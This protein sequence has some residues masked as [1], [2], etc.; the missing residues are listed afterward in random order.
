VLIETIRAIGIVLQP[1]MPETMGKL[2]DQLGVAY[3][4]RDFAAIAVKLVPGT[5][6]PTPQGLFP[7]VV[8]AE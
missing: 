5:A 6:L 2:L 3:D 4:K 7:R 8:E 1:F